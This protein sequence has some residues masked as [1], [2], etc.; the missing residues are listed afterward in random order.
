M[1]EKYNAYHLGIGG[2]GGEYIPQIGFGWTN[3]V[4]LTLLNKSNSIN[5]MAKS[6]NSINTSNIPNYINQLKDT[7]SSNNNNNIVISII[8]FLFIIITIVTR[9]ISYKRVNNI[10][11]LY[12]NIDIKKLLL[13]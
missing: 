8:L 1:Y 11:I 10:N 12:D 9:Y 4:I 3:G 5:T 2:G 13:N 6:S 7:I